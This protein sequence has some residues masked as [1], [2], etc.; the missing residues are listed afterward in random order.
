MNIAWRTI[1]LPLILIALALAAVTT[2]RGTP[3][4]AAQPAPG[5]PA[6]LACPEG[7]TAF[8]PAILTPSLA[9]A[10]VQPENQAQVDSIAP[11]LYWTPAITGTQFLI[12]V[13][14]S[15]DFVTKTVEV[16]TTKTLKLTDRT[17]QFTVPRNNFDPSKLHFWRIGVM[18]PDGMQ[19]SDTWQF[20]TAAFDASRL[21]G[22]PQLLTPANNS[23]IT[24]LEPVFTWAAPADADA[25]RVRVLEAD[26]K[27]TFKT[28]SVIELPRTDYSPTGFQPQIVYYWQVKVHSSYG[29][30]EYG[31]TPGWRFRTP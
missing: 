16:S 19:F 8:L 22:P 25:F 7:C 6:Q 3:I 30:G 20:T 29:W 31:P 11:T 15:S 9:P 21:P 28:S 17:P 10:L 27:T 14:T 24:T 26:Q 18:L 2:P 4:A 23:R 13:A 1:G 12:Q 5:A